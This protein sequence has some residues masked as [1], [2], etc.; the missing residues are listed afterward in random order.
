[1]WSSTNKSWR[2]TRSFARAAKARA[3][4]QAWRSTASR[5]GRR[6][7]SC[8]ARRANNLE[9]YRVDVWQRDVDNRAAELADLERT[10]KL[11]SEHALERH[12]A[13]WERPDA[14]LSDDK[15][16][17]QAR[18]WRSPEAPPSK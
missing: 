3:T 1:M 13:D 5:C 2:C 6:L 7:R 18:A 16:R 10:Y 17:E 9:F 12:G 14:K 4:Q 15:L 11:L 8:A